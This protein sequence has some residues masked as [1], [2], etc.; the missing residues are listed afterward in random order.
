MRIFGPPR[1]GYPGFVPVTQGGVNAR[2]AH[3]AWPWALIGSS[4]R[5]L[6]S[7]IPSFHARRC[8][9]FKVVAASI[10]RDHI[11]ISKNK[12]LIYPW[13]LR[14]MNGRQQALPA[15]CRSR[16][17][18][19]LLRRRRPRSLATDAVP[20]RLIPAQLSFELLRVRILTSC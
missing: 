14:C 9:T 5:D 11:A 4:L 20:A 10:A 6:R 18:N 16:H 17:R 12:T 19:V 8:R 3:V 2:C 15:P 1:C 7:T 13:G